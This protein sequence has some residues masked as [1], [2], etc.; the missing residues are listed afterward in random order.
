MRIVGSLAGAFVGGVVGFFGIIAGLFIGLVCWA[1]GIVSFLFLVAAT[2]QTARWLIAHDAAAG[3]ASIGCWAIAATAFA[4]TPV[5][6]RAIGLVRDGIAGRQQ[7]VAM[8]HI[9]RLRLAAR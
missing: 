9:G 6:V 5:L 7:S 1:C 2:W 8:A 4:V 3:R